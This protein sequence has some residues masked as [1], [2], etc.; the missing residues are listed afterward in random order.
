MEK[1]A[2]GMLNITKRFSGTIAN[3]NIILGW[4]LPKGA[5]LR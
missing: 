5:S 2:I 4:R 1:Y 3:D